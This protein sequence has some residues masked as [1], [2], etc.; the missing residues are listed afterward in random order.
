M[1][2]IPQHHCYSV[3]LHLIAEVRC[4]CG[5]PPGLTNGFLNPNQGPVPCNQFVNYQCNS[6]YIL[7]GNSRL[8]CLNNQYSGSAPFCQG[9]NA[10]QILKVVKQSDTDN[11]NLC[12]TAIFA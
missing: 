3:S 1:D 6:G 2:H 4:E 11:N 7:Q 10:M 12:T 8:Q 9:K 5:N